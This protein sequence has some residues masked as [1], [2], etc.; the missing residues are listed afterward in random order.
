MLDKSK[1][2]SVNKNNEDTA[3]QNNYSPEEIKRFDE[4]AENWWDP[5]GQYKTALEFN[6]ARVTYFIDQICAHFSLDPT[7]ELP[8]KGLR[9]LDVGCGGGLVCEPLAQA[10]AQV[11]GIDV[12]EMSIEVAKRHALQSGLDITYIHQHAKQTVENN[13]VPYN[14]VINA[15]VIEH[16]P[17]Q[18][19]LVKYCS[20][21]CK[22]DGCVI[23]ATLNRTLK[24]F[25]VGIIG[26]EYIMRY[27][28]VGT[29]SWH[30]FVTPFELNSMA[31]SARLTLSHEIG[32][33]YSLFS[34]RWSLTKSVAVNYIQVYKKL[35]DIRG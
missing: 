2:T 16:V 5:N 35:G 14:V 15:E 11:T 33:K 29:H 21:L 25:F 3:E 12:S 32:M 9:I 27:L 1:L 23:M 10:G 4:M 7:A 13:E 22:V 26:A 34:K 31:S 19:D 8:L 28:P 18:K 17:N 24:S 20:A 6:R 30:L